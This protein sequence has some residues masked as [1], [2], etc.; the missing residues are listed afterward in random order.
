MS[1]RTLR[2]AR[3][4]PG[5]W[6]CGMS[7]PPTV[8]RTGSRPGN[9][10]R[11]GRC[12]ARCGSPV[13]GPAVVVVQLSLIVD[14]RR[15]QRVGFEATCLPLHSIGQECP[16]SGEMALW[17]GRR[18]SGDDESTPLLSRRRTL[19]T[20]AQGG[21][22]TPDTPTVGAEQHLRSVPSRLVRPAPEPP[23]LDPTVSRAEPL[24]TSPSPKRYPAQPR[25]RRS[26]LAGA[27]RLRQ[28]LGSAERIRA[29][30][31]VA[32]AYSRLW[33]AM[34][35]ASCLDPSRTGRWRPPPPPAIAWWQSPPAA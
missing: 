24:T 31:P 33:G 13:A 27:R 14:A 7:P 30:D 19:T 16:D 6:A 2:R 29:S 9:G 5:K 15:L 12:P 35:L 34:S 23:C 3:M 8:C 17:V 1:S 22:D 28:R 20:E 18:L 11:R 21:D 4:V 10:G 25:N 26:R 32:A